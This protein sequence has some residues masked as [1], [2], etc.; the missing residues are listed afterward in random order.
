[1]LFALLETSKISIIL[2]TLMIRI[3]KYTFFNSI[4]SNSVK[5]LK[6]PVILSSD[7]EKKST[8]RDLKYSQKTL[9][10]YIITN[11]RFLSRTIQTPWICLTWVIFLLKALQ[12]SCLFY[13][14]R[15]TKYNC[16]DF[17][18]IIAVQLTIKAILQLISFEKLFI[19]LV[20][21]IVQHSHRYLTLKYV[22]VLG[23]R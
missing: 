8:F 6:K 9:I 20:L 11:I 15:I 14:Q 7:W 10:Y 22:Q 23:H 5:S 21:E 2:C 12:K 4:F 3:V 1:M 19:N 16:Y 17:C 13:L 18:Y